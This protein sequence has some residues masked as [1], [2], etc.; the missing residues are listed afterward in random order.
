VVIASIDQ[1]ACADDFGEIHTIGT[2]YT[3]KMKSKCFPDISRQIIIDVCSTFV[4]TAA[5]AV[6]ILAYCKRWRIRYWR[7]VL[8]EAF[9][10]WWAETDPNAYDYHAFVAFQV[11]DID[12]VT[13]KLLVEL[14]QKHSYR[15]CVHHRDFP[16]GAVLQQIIVDSIH[17]SRKTILVITP[18]FMQSEWCAFE[19]QMAR[20][21]LYRE[22]RDVIIPVILRAPPD[23]SL[24]RN[25]PYVLKKNYLK[26][27]EDNDDAQMLFWAK[28]VA[29]LGPATPLESQESEV[30]WYMPEN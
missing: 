30:L 7:Y 6:A 21:R 5:F 8:L 3:T 23:G 28:L 13:R 18:E 25:L 27:M 1:L 12:W 19:V 26:W 9:K 29:A 16:G 20:T 4:I 11:G 22:G 17:K 24:E 10:R 2:I 15:L 14:E